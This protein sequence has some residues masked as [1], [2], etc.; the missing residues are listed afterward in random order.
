MK[1]HLTLERDILGIITQTS[2]CPVVVPCGKYSWE[3]NLVM[4][5]CDIN[6][7]AKRMVEVLVHSANL[8]GCGEEYNKIIKILEDYKA[9]LTQRYRVIKTGCDW[10]DR[11]EIKE[12]LARVQQDIGNGVFGKTWA[13]IEE[14]QGG[15]IELK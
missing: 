13:E 1:R 4:Q 2:E 5:L 12:S 7:L 15:K 9:H 11:G 14:M 8:Y 10:E 3:S 6:S